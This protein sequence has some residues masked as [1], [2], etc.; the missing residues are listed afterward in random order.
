MAKKKGKFVV[1]S[2]LVDMMYVMNYN[3][4]VLNK[5]CHR[6]KLLSLAALVFAVAASMKSREQEEE[7]YRLSIRVQRL[8][9]KEGE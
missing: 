4:D 5:H 2:D 7:L 1:V 6:L 8:E 3:T 9:N